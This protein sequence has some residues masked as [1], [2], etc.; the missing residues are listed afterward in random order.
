MRSLLPN[1]HKFK[2]LIFSLLGFLIF[3]LSLYNT[4]AS[5]TPGQTLDPNCAPLDPGCFVDISFSETDPL[6]GAINGLIKS[7][8]S[9]N[10][11][12]ALAGVDFENPL[13]FSTGF[14][15]TT[16]T[17]VNNFSIGVS[18][19]QSLIGGNSAG[20]SLTLSSTANASK[21]SIIFGSSSYNE[22]LNVLS[23]NSS[24]TDFRLN[25]DVGSGSPDGGIMAVGTNNSGAT[26]SVAGAGT[27]MF[28][29]PRK[30][31]FRAGLVTGTEWD[32][33]NIG[34]YSFALGTNVTA[35]GVNSIA[36]GSSSVASDVGSIVI[37]N[38]STSSGLGSIAIGENVTSSG[39]VS[40]ALGKS[41][42]VSGDYSFGIGLDVSFVPYSVT[43]DNIMSIM[44]GNV[45]IG[46]TSPI[47]PLTLGSSTVDGSIFAYGEIDQGALADGSGV[48][49]MWYPRKAAF[50]AG[51]EGGV[52]W[53]DSNIGYYSASF[54]TS[55]I[56]SG[57]TSF[58][59]G[60]QSHATGDLSVSFGSMNDVSGNNSFLF[61][62]NTT[63]SGNNSFAIVLDSNLSPTV[64]LDNVVSIMGGLVGIGT[65]APEFSL[66]LG[67]I[68]DMNTDG[69]ILALGTYNSGASLSVTGSGSRM[70]WYPRKAAFRA[71]EA[72]GSVWDDENI[73]GY[74]VAF[75]N[76]SL[77]NNFNTSAFGN[78]QA[79]GIL[80]SAFGSSNS[81]GNM[82][83][84]FG[85]SNDV[86]GDF[87]LAFG[88]NSVAS[89]RS[90]L[91]FGLGSRTGFDPIAFT[92]TPGDIAVTVAGDRTTEFSNGDEVTVF[93]TS[94]VLGPS[95]SL[96]VNNVI[97]DGVNTT[98]D[99]NSN[100]DMTTDGGLIA[101][102][103]KGQF[104]FAGGNSVV[105]LNEG[106]ISLG[107]LSQSSG[108][109]S[110]TL[111]YG[112]VVSGDYSSALGYL[113]NVSGN[114]SFGFGDNHTITSNYSF[115]FGS[116]VNISAA[117]SFGFNLDNNNTVN[118][119]TNNVFVV[120]GGNVGIGVLSPSVALDVSGD[121]TISGLLT[122]GTL[123]MTS[124]PSYDD[125]ASAGGGGLTYGQV[126]Q[127]TGAG[128]PP[129]D[130]PGILMIK[131]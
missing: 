123:S 21:G 24:N 99:L 42:N 92:I 96:S 10:F 113:V 5:F 36:L 14:T 69:G 2:I 8:G 109:Y 71:G 38:L 11:S 110:V 6:V 128:A 77:A 88:D 4:F 116:G 40:T 107:G 75:G 57:S 17:I 12:A 62:Q 105:S 86:Y 43:G 22:S 46:T 82:A 3:G 51:Y 115:A 127:T 27:R 85:R 91:A 59:V 44:G 20:E 117:N 63:L 72:S 55:G 7:D 89:G 9:S 95:R 48:Q 104:G 39:I 64:A 74:S 50:R 35:S 87:A 60:N 93:P 61:G 49:M 23:L 121:A 34:N 119:N 98:F 29:Y 108:L 66:T 90:S 25:L 126:Y 53:N 1:L 130:V 118:I 125:D 16:N 122:T 45:G 120:M 30:S 106:S 47:A 67:D 70:F 68:T 26:L 52:Q 101:S 84:S 18:G 56:A 28:W 111:G 31:A 73:G 114:N 81:A 124:I 15:R 80:S 65:V 79:S 37:G 41:M 76:G 32:D 97:F 129:L 13:T 94:P 19:G 33:S 102:I 100:I 54:G 131:Q 78:G 83:F 112:N 103:Y 58:S